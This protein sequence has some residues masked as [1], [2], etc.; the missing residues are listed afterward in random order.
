MTYDPDW[1]IKKG[2][3]VDPPDPKFNPWGLNGGDNLTFEGDGKNGVSTDAIKKNSGG[4]PIATGCKFNSGD[5]VDVSFGGH[6]YTITHAGDTL[7]CD[8]HSGGT[9]WTATSGG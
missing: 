7:T 8:Q 5:T 2:W 6:N 9:A 1:T 4:T 3:N